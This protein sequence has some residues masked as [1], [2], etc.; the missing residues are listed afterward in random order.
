M[1]NFLNSTKTKNFILCCMHKKTISDDINEV[2]KFENLI[3]S[4]GG[5]VKFSMEE[6]IARNERDMENYRRKQERSNKKI[7]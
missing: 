2:D 5:T 7:I 6:S 1:K 3:K 4:L